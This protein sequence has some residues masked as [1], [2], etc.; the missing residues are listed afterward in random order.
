MADDFKEEHRSAH[1]PEFIEIDEGR[2]RLQRRRAILYEAKE[3]LPPFPFWMRL[4]SFFS[5]FLALILALLCLMSWSFATI[6]WALTLFKAKPL[7]RASSRLLG[8]FQGGLVLMN[9]LFVAAFSPYLGVVMIMAYFMLREDYMMRGG[10]S[11]ILPS[12]FRQFMGE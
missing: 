4:A 9:G 2:E 1:R 8:G 7:E 3:H 11:Y 10:L 5:S 6:L 12:H